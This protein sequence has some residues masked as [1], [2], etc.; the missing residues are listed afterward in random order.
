MAQ[1]R[2]DRKVKAFTSTL[3]LPQDACWSSP[4]PNAKKSC[5]STNSDANDA[6]SVCERQGHNHHSENPHLASIILSYPLVKT[7]SDTLSLMA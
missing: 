1:M 2:I 3:I 7:L 6:W 4:L 5:Q